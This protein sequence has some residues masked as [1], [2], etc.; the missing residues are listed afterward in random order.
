[1]LLNIIHPVSRTV[2]T[3]L[4]CIFVICCL[5]SCQ[6]FFTIL[7]KII[8]FKVMFYDNFSPCLSNSVQKSWKGAHW[9]PS[10]KEKVKTVQ[11]VVL[12]ALLS[13]VFFAVT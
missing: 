8:L 12:V 13:S 7:N 10:F 1:M 5:K 2:N 9:I 11:P 3:G 6:A 4:G